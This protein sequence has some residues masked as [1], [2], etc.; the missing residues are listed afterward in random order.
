MRQH[1]PEL[2]IEKMQSSGNKNKKIKKNIFQKWL[3][4]SMRLRSSICHHKKI[5]FSKKS[6]YI[7]KRRE[8]KHC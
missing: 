5:F 3:L 1:M 6:E 8:C 2:C 7:V 4:I